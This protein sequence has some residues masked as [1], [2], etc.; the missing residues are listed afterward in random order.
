MA[1]PNQPLYLL[2]DLNQVTTQ[3]AIQLV[4]QRSVAILLQVQTIILQ[5][6]YRAAMALVVLLHL[7]LTPDLTTHHLLARHNL[8]HQIL[9]MVHPN[10]TKII[11]VLPLV[12]QSLVLPSLSLTHITLL[13]RVFLIPFLIHTAPYPVL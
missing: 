4:L 3:V 5:F 6:K 12:V 2:M 8:L 9:T 1:R 11:M 7:Q 10:L 13:R